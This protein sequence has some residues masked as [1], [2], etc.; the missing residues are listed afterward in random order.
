[1]EWMMD[2][3]LGPCHTASRQAGPWALIGLDRGVDTRRPSYLGP[4]TL[5]GLV[6]SAL[7]LPG[8]L[9]W[10]S[11]I[12]GSRAHST[13]PCRPTE[14]SSG[15]LPLSLPLLPAGLLPCA[16]LEAASKLLQRR[17]RY[18]AV[19]QPLLTAA[20]VWPAI[21]GLSLAQAVE[22]P[23]PCVGRPLAIT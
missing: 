19:W 11:E 1:M 5:R 22:L 10:K 17:V 13:L 23:A 3:N 18:S 2:L 8:A 14:A 15:S 7:Q 12:R 4:A 21:V 20:D 9:P 6:H 16:E